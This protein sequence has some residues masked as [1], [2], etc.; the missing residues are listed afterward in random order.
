MKLY[1]FFIL[2]KISKLIDY[3]SNLNATSPNECIFFSNSKNNCCFN[4]NEQKCIFISKSEGSSN[5]HIL[6]DKNYLYNI[7]LFDASYK[8]K[9]GYCS[10]EY[11]GTII[12]FKRTNEKK[13]TDYEVNGLILNCN[14]SHFLHTKNLIMFLFLFV[15]F[16]L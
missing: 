10:I 8:D 3:C 4:K 9:D 16:V 12:V 7:S 14:L 11:N 15:L 2:L 1:L 13:I 6:C 5:E